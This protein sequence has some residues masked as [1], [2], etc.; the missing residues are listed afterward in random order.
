MVEP[1]TKQTAL[2]YARVSSDEQSR[3]YSLDTQLAAMQRYCKERDYTVVDEFNDV[4]TGTELDRP[5]MNAL[6]DTIDRVRPDVVI[7]YDVDRLGREV[8]VQAILERDLTARGARLEFVLGGDTSTPEGELLKMMKSAFAVYDNRQRVEKSKRGKRGRALA[9]HVVI[10]RPPFGYDYISE[11]HKGRLEVN[12]EE[13]ATVALMFDWLVD[14][15]L[16]TH[17]ITRRLWDRQIPSR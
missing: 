4:H 3:G 15:R 5:G 7:L 16:T 10:G 2:L 6:I 14:E 12:P 13:A 17:A 1:R 11:P 8:I 9:G